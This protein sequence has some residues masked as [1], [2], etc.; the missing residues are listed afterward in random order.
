MKGYE[1]IFIIIGCLLL[2]IVIG[3]AYIGMRTLCEKTDE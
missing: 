1:I 2:A 3:L